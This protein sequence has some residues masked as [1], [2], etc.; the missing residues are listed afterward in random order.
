[1][2]VERVW[3]RWYPAL[4]AHEGQHAGNAVMIARRGETRLLMLPPRPDCQLLDAD[5]Q[6]LARE[7]LEELQY[8]DRDYDRRTDHGASEGAALKTYLPGER[9][10]LH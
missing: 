6:R 1:S 8:I 10:A 5:A 9:D 2:E 7:M 3:A 4:Q